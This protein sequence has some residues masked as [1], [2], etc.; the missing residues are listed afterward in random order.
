[1]KIKDVFRKI[2]EKSAVRTVEPRS[3]P[4]IIFQPKPPEKVMVLVNK[5][6]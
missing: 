1:M 3:F 6:K 4:H 2:G 5:E